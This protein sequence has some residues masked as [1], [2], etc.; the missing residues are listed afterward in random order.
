VKPHA[1][2]GLRF[3]N[4]ASP[5]LHPLPYRENVRIGHSR[6]R[7][8]RRRVYRV[9]LGPDK[10]WEN[11]VIPVGTFVDEIFIQPTANSTIRMFHEATF[12]FRIPTHLK[13]NALAF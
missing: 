1:R 11:V 10:F 2:L 7:Y 3:T 12:N 6:R 13:L 5:G 8:T 9:I 4:A